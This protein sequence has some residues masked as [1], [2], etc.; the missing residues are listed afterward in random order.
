[1]ER[2]AKILIVDDD[3]VL[4]ESLV[5]LVRRTGAEVLQAFD[6]HQ[7]LEIIRHAEIDVVIS[8]VNMPGMNGIELLKEIKQYD[9]DI[10]VLIMSGTVDAELEVE[11]LRNGAFCVLSKPFSDKVLIPMLRIAAG[12]KKTDRALSRALG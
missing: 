8:D 12:L 9:R 2:P 11:A 4:N 3:A 1:M 5:Y 6:A 7:A 10:S